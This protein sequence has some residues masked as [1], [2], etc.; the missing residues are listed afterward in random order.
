MNKPTTESRC[1]ICGGPLAIGLDL[2]TG[3]LHG[4]NAQPVNDGRC[5]RT[6]DETIVIPT[7]IKTIL[8][9]RRKDR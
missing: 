3:W 8:D 1:S 6:C 5:C 2:I 7:R 4:A 9:Q